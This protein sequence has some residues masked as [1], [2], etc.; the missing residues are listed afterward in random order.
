MELVPSFLQL[1]QPF[2]SAMTSPTFASFTTLLAGWSFARR[3]TVSGALLAADGLHDKHHS[4]YHR[5]FSAA[6]W[7]LQAV[8]LG[9]LDLILRL[10]LASDATVYLV[11][12]DTLCR[13][14]GRKIFGVGMH[15]DPLLTG[16][17]LSNANK[18][19]KSRG[20]CWVI[21]GVVVVLPLR[22]G[23]YF[24]LPVLFRLCLNK[25]S[26][27]KH[28]QCYRSRPELGRQMLQIVCQRYP[29]RHFHLLVD[30]AYG[31]QE[32]LRSLPANCDLTARWL[33]DVRLCEPAVPKA[34]SQKGPQPKRGAALPSPRQMLQQRCRQVELDGY[35]QHRRY[36]IHDTLGC[37][38]TVPQ[39]LLR[40]VVSEPL[41]PSGHP[42]PKEQA[43]FYSTVTDTDAQQVLSGF[44]PRWSVEVT[45]HDT[46]QQLG[47]Q[48]P[49]NR[50]EPAVRRT[51]PVLMLLYSVVVLWFATA[52]HRHWRA[53]RR[54]WYPS[55]RQASF[56]DML[57]TLRDQMVRH[58]LH[59]MLRPRSFTEGLRKTLKL[60]LRLVRQAA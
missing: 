44:A 26:A 12:D 55:K 10:A 19:L 52:G 48:Q 43:C 29:Q 45:I 7:D 22:P 18:S 37:L 24:C 3:H 42:R 9:L 49:Q 25:R 33:L 21:L 5:V 53:P 32:T 34:K 11:I 1:L 47:L 56:A 38:Y 20:H 46:K 8:G 31:G 59:Q 6:R 30:S 27:A 39:R 41:S 28:H 13:R 17:K 40:L 50:S 4:A 14:T 2:S 54:P 58:H 23:F 16:R 51:A 57:G 36:R 60:T 15:Y 35:G